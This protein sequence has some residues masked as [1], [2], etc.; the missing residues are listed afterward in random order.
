[1]KHLKFA[2]F[3]L[4][5]LVLAACVLGCADS[6]SRSNSHSKKGSGVSSAKIDNAAQAG[7]KPYFL[8]GQEADLIIF[9]NK[10]F[11]L[12]D[13]IQDGNYTE[14]VYQGNVRLHENGKAVVYQNHR[15]EYRAMS[16][17]DGNGDSE[18]I[19]TMDPAYSLADMSV[20]YDLGFAY[21]DGAASTLLDTGAYMISELGPVIAFKYAMDADGDFED[22]PVEAFLIHND[23]SLQKLPAQLR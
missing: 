21:F 1:M 13:K 23:H 16:I 4:C 2:A 3:I 10:V 5:I 22:A 11:E 19:F 12:P 14:D 6:N 7:S 18:L 15:L 8:P 9:N 20:G 17:D